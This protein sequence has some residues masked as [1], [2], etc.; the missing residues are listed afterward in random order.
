M[1]EAA[2]M[3]DSQPIIGSILAVRD[4]GTLVLVFVETDDDRTVPVLIDHRAYHGLLEA[5]DCRPDELVGRRISY[6]GNRIQ[7]LD[8]E[9]SQ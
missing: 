7:F 9:C 4:C 6:D 8:R 5:G 3:T 2:T 1:L